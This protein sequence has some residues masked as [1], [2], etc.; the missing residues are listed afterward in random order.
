V[1]AFSAFGI[2]STVRVVTGT[3]ALAP[4]N[5][6]APTVPTSGA[7]SAACP[8][9][10]YDAT[11]FFYGAR[12]TWA[13]VADKDLAY[14]ELKSTLTDSDAA[15]NY[16]W[17]VSTTSFPDAST[18]AKLL[19]T[20]FDC[21]SASPAPDGFARVRTV[22]RSGVAS[23]WLRI[24]NILP[25]AIVGAAGMALQEPSNVTTTG[26]TQGAGSLQRKVVARQ[27]VYKQINLTGGAASETYSLDISNSGFSAA[28]D[29]GWFQSADQG[30]MLIRYDYDSS[31]STVAE[32]RIT[33]E[34]TG[35]LAEY[36]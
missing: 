16:T 27:P 24:G 23:A 7:I 10:R 19:V 12:I 11:S 8:A 15:T 14:Y 9:K 20:F 4:V 13:P 26:I 3:D 34:I 33:M 1:Q 6:T 36:T 31:S 25:T 28:P 2:G 22:S 18:T 32:L 30:G 21:Y 35:E 17:S 29:V 5:T